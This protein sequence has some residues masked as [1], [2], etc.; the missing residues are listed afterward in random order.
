MTNRKRRTPQSTRFRQRAVVVLVLLILAGFGTGALGL[1]QVQ[2]VRGAE[3]S[4]RAQANQLHD[5]EVPPQRGTIYD[6]QMRPIAESAAAS[7]VFINPNLLNQALNR[8]EIVQAIADDLAPILGITPEHVQRQA[9]F[10]HLNHMRLQGR[11]DD[12]TMQLVNEFRRRELIVREQTNDPAFADGVRDVRTTFGR[13]VQVQPDVVRF[14]RWGSLAGS[15]IGFT[16]ADDVGR[17]GLEL[18][19]NQALTGLP[20][21]I[22][23]ARSAA[24]VNLPIHY[25]SIYDPQPGNSL[26]LTIDEV[27]QRFLERSL[28]QARIDATADAANGIVMCVRTGAIL[29]MASVPSFDPNNHQRI[30]DE[31]LRERILAIPDEEER[32]QAYNHAMMAQW[33]NGAIEL[34][35]E[36]GSVFKVVTFAAAMEE[37]VVNMNSTFHCTGVMQ[38]ANRRMRCHNRTGHGTL[39]LAQ[40][41]MNSCNPFTIHLGQLMG[42]DTFYDYFEAF[43]FTTPTGIDLPGEFRPRVGVNIHSRENT[44]TVELASSSFGQSFEASP[45]QILTAVSAIA[46]GGRLMQPFIVAREIDSAGRVVRETQ[47]VVRRQVVSEQTAAQLSYIMEQTVIDGTGRNAYV[48][49]ARVA[50]KTGTSQKLSSGEGYVASFAAFAPAD[51]PQFAIL[52]AIDNPRGGVIS[53]GQLA[54]PVAAEVLENL[55][56]YKNIEMRYT[57]TERQAL[58]GSTPNVVQMAP[59]AARAQLQQQGFRV[60][61]IG[62]GEQVLHQIPAPRQN[63][64]E[65]GLIVLYTDNTVAQRMV[66]VPD[67][68][69]LTITQAQQA[70]AAAGLNIRLTGN[71]NSHRLRTNRQ[72]IPAGTQA[73]MG[74]NITVHFVTSFG[75]V[76]QIDEE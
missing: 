14:Y 3:F 72:S 12:E 52:I 33:R 73:R 27:A 49:G 60:E 61:I 35:Y 67:L 5:T 9:S 56:V 68:T 50:G 69:G 43:G 76:D 44:R 1:V 19:H 20:G 47:P 45:I 41:F 74:E 38:V 39:T 66:T 15:L 24:G 53:G 57:E 36:P 25:S 64:P 75:I 7:L 48:A 32:R 62:Q 65:G 51:N 40:G 26:V 30:A 54:A 18:M 28:E 13:Y 8:D 21:R 17:S 63:I 16:G 42:S 34:T 2:L 10:T 11:V 22:V 59:E 70:A 37:G 6:S 58:G 4:A 31:D 46:N 29:A 23:S 71:F 55:M